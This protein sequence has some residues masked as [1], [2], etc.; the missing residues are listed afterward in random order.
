MAIIK[1]RDGGLHRHLAAFLLL[2]MSITVLIAL[3]LQYIGGYIPCKLCLDERV[4]YYGGIPL[5]VIALLLGGKL[6]T[7]LLRLLFLALGIMLL[8][9]GGL[10]IYHAGAEWKFWPGPDDCTVTTAI[11]IDNAANLLDSLNET[12]PAACDEASFVFLGLSLAGWNAAVS[13][14]LAFIAAIGVAGKIKR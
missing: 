14:F 6:P 2:V 3:G 5:M 1:R 9:N 13:L 12:R 10:S 11:V 8:Y 7:F 4:P